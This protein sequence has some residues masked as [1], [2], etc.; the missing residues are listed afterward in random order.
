MTKKYYLKYTV[1]EPNG[2][3]YD[4]ERFVNIK[5]REASRKAIRRFES[6]YEARQKERN[7]ITC[8]CRITVLALAVED[9]PRQSRAAQAIR[10]ILGGVLF[11]II[12]L[13]LLYIGSAPW[14]K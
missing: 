1:K 7:G 3:R 13:G 10:I 6:E 12:L 11:W 14:M 9:N 5:P 2:H 8:V 4:F